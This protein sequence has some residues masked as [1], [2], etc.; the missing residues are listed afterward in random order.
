[1]DDAPEPASSSP[2][3]GDTVSAAGASLAC[4][5]GQDERTEPPSV[6]ASCA[7]RWSASP[8]DFDRWWPAGRVLGGGGRIMAGEPLAGTAGGFPSA[9]ACCAGDTLPLA[10][11]GGGGPSSSA[12]PSPPSSPSLLLLSSSS[13]SSSSL[14]LLSSSSSP[15]SSSLSTSKATLFLLVDR[16]DATDT[17][18]ASLRC[19]S[20]TPSPCD[21]PGDNDV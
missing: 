11:T 5:D 13:P 4:P 14:L 15:S 21:A 19:S 1:M 3:G 12:L 17:F 8:A 9:A 16:P 18:D 2:H 6:E 20:S 10:G 7:A